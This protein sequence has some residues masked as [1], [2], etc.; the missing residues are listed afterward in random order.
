MTEPDTDTETEPRQPVPLPKGAQRMLRALVDAG[1]VGFLDEKN[2][3]FVGNPSRPGPVAPGTP[4]EW[5]TLVGKDLVAGE[6]GLLIP[7]RR[8]RHLALHGTM[9]GFDDTTTDVD[10]AA[11]ARNEVDYL[12][13]E[14]LEA[15]D[16]RFARVATSRREALDILLQEGLITAA[17]ARQDV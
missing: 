12:T 3:L 1:G 17:E 7:T 16:G 6:R 10:L 11:W 8:G 5:I 13:S 2:C 15:I 14:L 4:L 9:T